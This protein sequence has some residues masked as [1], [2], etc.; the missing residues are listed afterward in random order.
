VASSFS[1]SIVTP[2]RTVLNGDAASLQV[3]AVEGSLGVLPG[4]APLLAQLGAGECVVRLSSG[5]NHT[6]AVAGG[7][8]DVS[9][10]RV[11]ILAD[12]AEFADEIDADRAE[13]AL[14]KARGLVASVSGADRE[15]ALAAIRRAQARLRVAR[16][17]DRKA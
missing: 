8:L 7:F 10:S 9:A 4:H 1:L 11:T 14:D 17:N 12:T 2:E 13:R 3:M 15:E 16:G 6:L 5:E